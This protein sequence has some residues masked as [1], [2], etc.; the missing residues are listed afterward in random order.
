M[1]KKSRSL[2]YCRLCLATDRHFS[3]VFEDKDEGKPVEVISKILSIEIRETDFFSKLICKACLKL[4]IG[5]HELQRI[6][7]ETQKHL[8][9]NHEKYAQYPAKRKPGRQR[10]SDL[11]SEVNIK[12]EIL[13]DDEE[14]E[15]IPY[16]PMDVE[17]LVDE[18]DQVEDEESDQVED[19]ESDQVEDSNAPL[20][21]PIDTDI[22]EAA[23][24]DKE[25][26][27]LVEQKKG[28][29]RPSGFTDVKRDKNKEFLCNVCRKV[30]QAKASLAA[31]FTKEH[32][33]IKRPH[34][35]NRC[36]NQ[37]RIVPE[38]KAHRKIHEMDKDASKQFEE[39][40]A[41][42]LRRCAVCKKK[43]NLEKL[44]KHWDL[45]HNPVL[46]PFS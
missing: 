31:H 40:D 19:D 5:A 38:L 10:T 15:I 44:E 36:Y 20:P 33:D 41:D 24:D 29:G 1:G 45:R 37:F 32:N 42:K 9:L 2:K 8:L 27:L 21:D 6:T 3:S 23:D 16:E 35:C 22:K 17:E 30:F 14:D 34:K 4:L 12:E 11:S 7:N 25:E 26:E 39:G 18:S 46:N 28:R 13:E 43:L